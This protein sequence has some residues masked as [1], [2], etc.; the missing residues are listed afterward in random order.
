[1]KKKSIFLI[2]LFVVTTLLSTTIFLNNMKLKTKSISDNSKDNTSMNIKTSSD[3]SLKEVD[4]A[5]KNKD[6]IKVKQNRN[7]SEDKS[8]IIVSENKQKINS[9]EDKPDIK[10]SQ[11]KDNVLVNTST[12]TNN[13]LNAKTKYINNKVQKKQINIQN[14]LGKLP[15]ITYELKQGETLTDI[16][17]RYE[18]TCNLNTTVKMIKSINNIE[19]ENYID[20]KTVLSIPETTIKSGTM[21][22]VVSGD[23][24]YKIA[25]LYDSKY[26]VDSIMNLVVYVNNLPNNDLPLGETIFLP[27]ID[28]AS[29]LR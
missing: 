5:E 26:D 8:D 10:A 18:N 19:D 14:Y 23:T 16:A 2:T 24:W 13:E 6:T 1:M 12:G 27:I 29:P 3:N 11:D 21:Y 22:K 25:N 7:T 9:S 4:L 20:A 17:R 28:G 15:C